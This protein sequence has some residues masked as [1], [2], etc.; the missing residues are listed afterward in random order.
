MTDH[1]QLDEL[2]FEIDTIREQLAR[3]HA[4]AQAFAQ[5]KRQLL[6]RLHRLES[7]YGILYG[8][9]SVEEGAS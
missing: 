7:D 6:E 9:L 8:R 4:D 3:I 1:Q 5:Q 2:K